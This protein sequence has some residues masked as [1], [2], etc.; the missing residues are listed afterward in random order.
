MDLDLNKINITLSFG[1]KDIKYN[2]L[3]TKEESSIIPVIKFNKENN[4]F[5]QKKS[6][7]L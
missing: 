1:S 2:D 4:K 6:N 5:R 7:N 3:L